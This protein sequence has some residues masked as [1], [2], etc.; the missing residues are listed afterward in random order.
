MRFPVVTYQKGY[1]ASAG[2]K[3]RGVFARKN[4]KK[5]ELVESSPYIEI[6]ARDYAVLNKT[7]VTFYWYEVKGRKCAIGLGY[8]SLYNHSRDPNAE[9]SLNSHRKKITIKAIR[10]IRKNEEIV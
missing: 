1:V 7:I 5:G 3:G 10:N 4:L 2:S 8:T 6:P 9:F